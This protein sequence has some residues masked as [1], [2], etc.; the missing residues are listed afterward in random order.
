M[1]TYDI[2]LPRIT[3]T[4]LDTT[5]TM[6]Q[7]IVG[8]IQN[9]GIGKI[10]LFDLF[11][12]K[13][14]NNH[15]AFISLE[16]YVNYAAVQFVRSINDRGFAKLADKN[17]YW[18][19]VKYV[20]PD[21]RRPSVVLNNA[22]IQEDDL[23]NDVLTEKDVPHDVLEDAVLVNDVLEDDASEERLF[24]E[25]YATV[26]VDDVSADDVLVQDDASE[27]RLF[28]EEY[29][30]V[31]DDDIL[32]DDVFFDP[33]PNLFQ[34][35]ESDVVSFNNNYV[36]TNDYID[37]NIIWANDLKPLFPEWAQKPFPIPNCLILK[38]ED[39]VSL[40]AEN[41]F[42]MF[43]RRVLGRSLFDELCSV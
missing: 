3:I 13:K 38:Q 37:N 5:E 22:F 10:T 7:K 14:H 21:Y 15:Y 26:L 31:L 32:D 19:V 35:P 12:S 29:A 42:E 34:M 4:N 30:A 9:M 6:K 33:E 8:T 23:S 41:D 16:L 2:F 39:S 36:E 28:A 17:Y 25:E 24:T 1:S 18:K 27:E 43:A 11:F 20:L 40:A